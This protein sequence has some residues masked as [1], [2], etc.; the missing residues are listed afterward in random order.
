MTV[1]WK[2]NYS[3]ELSQ[4]SIFVLRSNVYLFIYIINIITN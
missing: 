2:I 4:N 1:K 3:S